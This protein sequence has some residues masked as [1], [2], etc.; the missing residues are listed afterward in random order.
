MK[1]AARLAVIMRGLPGSGKSHWVNE[2]I[3]SQPVEISSR[4]LS[5]GCFSTDNYFYRNGQYQFDARRLS[6]Y[7]QRNLTGFIQALSEREP[8][9][10]CDNTNLAQW[11]S[12]AYEAAARSLGYQVRFVLIGAPENRDHQALCA[13]RNRHGVPLAQ[14]ERMAKQFEEF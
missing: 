14:I 2:F 1:L 3:A 11:E 8:I 13:K 10:I 12:I 7:H 6:E 9:V 4:V 5:S